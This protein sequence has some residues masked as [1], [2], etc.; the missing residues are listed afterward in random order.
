MNEIEKGQ[1]AITT[2]QCFTRASGSLADFPAL[3]KKVISEKVWEKRIHNGHLVELPSL[4]AL[5]TEKPIRGWGQDPD[6]I[7][8]VIQDDPE[9][10]AMFRE[11]M[12]GE[13]GRPASEESNNNIIGLKAV[14]GTSK[15][16]TCDRL[17][18]ERPDLFEEVVAGKLSA[19]AAAIKA[20][21]RKKKTPFEQLWHWWEKASHDERCQFL[22]GVNALP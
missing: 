20:G 21:F 15:A 12:K 14:Q 10:L 4:R 2:V 16:Y 3:L 13:A 8:A 6:K 5:I 7:Q 18:R 9:A 19:N 1:I 11:A 17:K 22:L